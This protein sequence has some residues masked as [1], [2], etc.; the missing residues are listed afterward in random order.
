[1]RH[2]RSIALAVLFLMGSGAYVA[3]SYFFETQ[4]PVKV[5]SVGKGAIKSYVFVSGNVINRDELAINSQVPGLVAKLLVREGDAVRK[6]EVLA[7]LDDR[8]AAIRLN[9][10]HSSLRSAE[11]NLATSKEDLAHLEAVFAVGGE[12]Q[13]TVNGAAS[14][15]KTAQVEVAQLRDD[16]RLAQMQLD[17]FA[18]KSPL[19]GVVTVSSARAGAAINAGDVL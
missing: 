19:D 2:T 12:S 8:E 17:K 4:I 3:R 5:V 13:K 9:K 10:Y 11:Q 1:M 6:G 16:Y 14:R 18:I 15:L 7:F